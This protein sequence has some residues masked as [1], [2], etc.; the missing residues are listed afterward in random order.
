[1]N[2]L[3]LDKIPIGQRVCVDAIQ[4]DDAIVSRLFEM[5]LLE[6]EIVEVI[7]IAPLG[8]PIQIRLRDYRLCLRKQE[9]SR[10]LVSL[11]A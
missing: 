9:A 6:G 3:S 2:A 4:G 11:V 1:M 7:G 10:V 5:G 8:D